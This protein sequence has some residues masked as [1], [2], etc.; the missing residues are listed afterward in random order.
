MAIALDAYTTATYAFPPA[1]FSHTVSGSNRLLLVGVVSEFSSTPGGGTHPSVTYNGVAMT[2]LASTAD[3]HSVDDYWLMTSLFALVAP[4]TGTHDVVVT[5]TAADVF[6][7]FARSYTGVNQ[8]TPV[9]NSAANVEDPISTDVPSATNNL[10]LDVIGFGWTEYPSAA[11]AGQTSFASAESNQGVIW[12]SYEAGASSVTMSWADIAGNVGQVVTEIVV[13]GGSPGGGSAVSGTMAS[14]LQKITSSLSGKQ[15]QT[16]TVASTL[17][18]ITSSLSG[19]QT[20]TGTVAALL[21]K[22]LFAGTAVHRQQGTVASTLTRVTFAG[23]GAQP[24]TA[25]VAGT[26]SR[27][28]FAGTAQQAQT[29]IVAA[30]LTDLLFAGE[31]VHGAA[32]PSSGAMASVLTGITFAGTA[33]QNLIG[34]MASTLQLEL[35]AATGVMAPKGV[36]ASVLQRVLFAGVG[37]MAPKGTLASSLT[38]LRFAGAGAQLYTGTLAATLAKILFS[39]TGVKGYPGTLAATLAHLAFAGTGSQK[40]LGVMAAVLEEILFVGIGRHLIQGGP[41]RA[42]MASSR[43][44][45]IRA[46]RIPIASGANAIARGGGRSVMPQGERP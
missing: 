22:V 12:G 43:T 14:A 28:A 6:S 27:I 8:T 29:G 42:I 24:F 11:G 30:T 13:V 26:L 39:G 23:S 17:K 19:K 9:A 16:G 20:Q 10:V 45:L 38:D 37:S 7:L 44:E 40:N 5:Y 3:F 15:T 36:L 25:T 35:F 46:S 18:L 21:Q 34:V 41:A 4:D 32:A 2:H 31:G 33:R 1:T